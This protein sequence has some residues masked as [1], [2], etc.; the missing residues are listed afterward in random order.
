[1]PIG[2]LLIL[3]QL[4]PF[5]EPVS[6]QNAAPGREQLAECGL[7]SQRFCARVNHHVADL[8]I[9]GP[10]WDK[11]PTQRP[12]PSSAVCISNDRGEQLP[13]RNVVTWRMD[14]G[15]WLDAIIA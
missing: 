3:I 2:L 1:D 8:L 5:I 13:R 11:S 12:Q 9:L 14:I 4:A 15:G 6:G 7:V 10:A